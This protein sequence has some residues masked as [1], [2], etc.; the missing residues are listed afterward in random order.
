MKH[1]NKSEKAFINFLW[2]KFD[3]MKY[4]YILHAYAISSYKMIR[5]NEN[6]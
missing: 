5:S 1:C 6:P 3:Q 4:V 2:H